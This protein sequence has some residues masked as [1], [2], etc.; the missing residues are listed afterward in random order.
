MVEIS[1]LE[2]STFPPVDVNFD[3]I[4]LKVR[5]EVSD[6]IEVDCSYD[7]DYMKDAMNQVG[8]SLR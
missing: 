2:A 3:N 6:E 4:I 7:L 8:A 5:T 1:Y